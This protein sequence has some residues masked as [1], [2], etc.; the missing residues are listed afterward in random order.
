[1]AGVTKPGRGGSGRT[2]IADVATLAGVSPSAVSKIVNGKGSFP[3]A[4]R[5]RV[6]RAAAQLNWTP[7]AAAVA[8]R[9]AR[10]RAIGMVAGRD[11]DLLNSDPYFTLLIAGIESELA[12][13]D[14]GLLLHIV[15]EEPGAEERAYRRLADERRVDA[16]ILTESR[17]GDGRFALL[18]ALGLPAVLV[19]TPWQPDPVPTVQAA[20]QEQGVTEAVDHLVALGHRRLAYVSGPEDRVHTGHRR[21][22]FL[23]ALRRRGLSPSH[24][25]TSDFAGHTTGEV[26]TEVL[27]REDAP[28]AIVFAN[29]MMALAGVSA[30]RRLGVDVPGRLSVVG[31]DD[32]PVGRMLHP[33]LTTVRQDLAQLGRAAALDLLRRLGEKGADRET[34][35]APPRL[36][37][38]ESTAPAP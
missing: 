28:T 2:T 37:V 32:L 27:G 4:T 11:P 31:H 7:S 35:V 22:V 8:L 20:G 34:L 9:G 33:R 14:Y 30:A 10:T 16:V 17:V 12:P 3:E 25:L 26:V 15:G 13:R 23:D 6:R 19:G 5:E 29:D 24:L 36:V 1:M 18:R 38:R 21:Q